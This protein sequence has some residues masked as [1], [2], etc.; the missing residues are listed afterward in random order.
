M[1]ILLQDG[2]ESVRKLRK[3]EEECSEDHCRQYILGASACMREETKCDA[4]DVG[5]NAFLLKPLDMPDLI[6]TLNDLHHGVPF[7]K[8]L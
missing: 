6:Q 2:L 3:W 4:M 5:M 8:V 7:E 1:H